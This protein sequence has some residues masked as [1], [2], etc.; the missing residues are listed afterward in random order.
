MAAPNS[1]STAGTPRWLWFAFGGLLTI[2]L[3]MVGLAVV[4]VIRSFSAAPAGIDTPTPIASAQP[5]SIVDQNQ[6]QLIASPQTVTA[7]SPLAVFGSNWKSGEKVT[8]F[9]R[10]PSKPTDPIMALGSGQASNDGTL[11]VTVAYPTD[12]R[13]AKLNKVDVIV[14]YATSGAY[15]VTSI[16]VQSQ[17]AM[18]TST[19]P[20]IPSAT[21]TLIP[22]TKTPT[23]VPPTSTRVLPTATPVVI[24]DWRGEYYPNQTLT[25]A[26]AVVRNDKDVNFDWNVGSPFMF[27]PADYFSARWT[28]SLLFAAKTY[29]FT[30]RADDGV[31]LWI[32]GSLIIEEWHSAAPSAY[33]RDVTLGAG[34]HAIRLEY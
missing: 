31:R 30:V 23:R 17:I 1:A 27:I 32:D 2:T 22:P 8:I 7:G 25:G 24:T 28:R 5:T 19:A 6:P 11:A 18:A 14:Q 21:S 26:P 15:Y 13:W 10:D 4:L 20:P 29:R 9:L 16:N 12:P 3:L 33:A 34:W